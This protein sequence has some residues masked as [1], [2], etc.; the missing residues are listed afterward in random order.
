MKRGGAKRGGVKQMANKIDAAKRADE[1]QPRKSS[2]TNRPRKLSDAHIEALREFGHVGVFPDTFPGL[3]IR[4][5]IRK[6]SWVFFQQHRMKG[7]R[8][9]TFEVLGE[10]PVMTVAAARVDA[11]IIA[12]RIASGTIKPSKRAAVTLEAAI[13]DYIAHL[14]K[15]A[16]KRGKPAR[17]A[18]VA[19]KIADKVILPKLGRWSLADLSNAP[20]VV[21]DWHIEITE[22]HG[23]VYANHAARIVRATYNRTAKLDR[24]LPVRLPTSAVE[25]NDEEASKKALDFKN[26]RKWFAT[27]RKLQSAVHRAYH[28]TGLL[29]GA[30]PGELS[31]VK[32]TDLKPSQ[33]CLVIG[34]AKAGSAISIPLSWPMVR[35]LKIA[36]DEARA[37][38]S[39]SEFIFPATSQ[40]V[41]DDLPATGNTLRHAFKT[42]CSLDLKVDD[43]ISSLLMGHALDGVSKK[44]ISKIIITSGPALRS[45]QARIS[46]RIV[47]LLGLSSAEFMAELAKPPL[48]APPRERKPAK[49]RGPRKREDR[50]A[51]FKTWYA[52]NQARIV[53]KRRAERAALK[54]PQHDAPLVPSLPTG[55]RGPTTRRGKSKAVA[56]G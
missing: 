22:E 31:R 37:S 20:A 7:T 44:Y 43:T 45:E 24:S 54:S 23:P 25:F 28:L 51:Y 49:P 26:Y 9:H 39:T 21:R 27:W 38:D 56:P 16:A 53:E 29:C 35:A 42:L 13:A 5:G 32:W 1:W 33:R 18:Y 12:G 15:Q 48:P 2:D 40:A 34:N 41:R 11:K 19:R 10:W 8:S 50:K 46:R 30:R 3:R 52:K 17:W 14:E 47:Q 6:A 36:R 55:S 4:I